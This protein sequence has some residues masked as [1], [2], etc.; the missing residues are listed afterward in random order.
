M[1]GKPMM[2]E[3]IR[4]QSWQVAQVTPGVV[5]VGQMTTVRPP[6]LTLVSM[7]TRSGC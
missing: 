1:A 7:M 5:L 6:A 4:E 2:V 3:R